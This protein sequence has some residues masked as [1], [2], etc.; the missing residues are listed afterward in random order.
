L[1]KFNFDK[2]ESNKVF[3]AAEARLKARTD[4][5]QKQRDAERTAWEQQKKEI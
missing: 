1:D 4:F 3:A 2:E 5:Y